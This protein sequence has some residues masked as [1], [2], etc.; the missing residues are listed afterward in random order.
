MGL[1]HN[2][3]ITSCRY[4]ARRLLVHEDHGLSPDEVKDERD[5]YQKEYRGIFRPASRRIEV[6]DT[7]IPDITRYCSLVTEPYD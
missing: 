2:F 7:V 6:L 3:Q 1:V 4:G 5:S